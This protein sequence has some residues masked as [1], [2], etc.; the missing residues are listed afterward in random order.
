MEGLE[1]AFY[2]IVMGRGGIENRMMRE[3]RGREQDKERE[4]CKREIKEA[5]KRMRN[6]KAAGIDEI[7]SEAW[8]YEGRVEEMG[9]NVL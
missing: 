5:V 4:I 3:K 7:P 9:M 2:K 6:R 8:K 1:Y